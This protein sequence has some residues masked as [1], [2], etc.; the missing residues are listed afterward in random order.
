MDQML[1]L[2]QM[3]NS[4]SKNEQYKF[5]NLYTSLKILIK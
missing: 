5:L 2:K 4:L 3:F 1:L